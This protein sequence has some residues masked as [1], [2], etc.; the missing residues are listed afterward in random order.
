MLCNGGFMATINKDKK[1]FLGR[2]YNVETDEWIRADGTG[3]ITGFDRDRAI[4]GRE[5]I[6]LLDIWHLL[7]LN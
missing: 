5:N 4:D 1:M 3:K 7:G 2:R 6:P